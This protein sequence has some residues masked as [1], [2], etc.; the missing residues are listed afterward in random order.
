M[1]HVVVLGFHDPKREGSQQRRC[2]GGG[3]AS[4]IAASERAVRIRA[5]CQAAE[6]S[7]PGRRQFQLA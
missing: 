2:D 4:A 7:V 1:Q 5:L 3:L 6:G